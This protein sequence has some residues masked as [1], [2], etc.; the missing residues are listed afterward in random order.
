MEL[1]ATSEEVVS[2]LLSEYQAT[3]NAGS[4]EELANAKA[5]RA[6]IADGQLR[7][8]LHNALEAGRSS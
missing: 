3:F 7:V 6:P 4:H 5:R 8:Q 1:P 2:Q